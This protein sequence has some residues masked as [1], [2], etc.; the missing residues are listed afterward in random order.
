MI[1]R[2]ELLR[3]KRIAS[4]ANPRVKDWASLADRKARERLGL[5]LAEGAKLVEE[6]LRER[7]SGR[8]RP[9]TLLVS[10]SG[11]ERREAGGLFATA[12]EAG[13]ERVSLS[14]ECFAK[15]SGLKNA[16]GLALALTYSPEE[17]DLATFFDSPDV[18]W[19]IAA[20]VQDPGNAGALAR[21]ALAA[22]CSGCLFLDG[23]DPASPKFLRGSMGAAFR[24]P[25]LA[26][27]A[28]AFAEAWPS[29]GGR[30]IVASTGAA[31]KDFRN[32]DYKPPLALLVGG[33]RGIPAALAGLADD[34]AH[35]PLHGRVESLNLAVAA[36]VILFEAERR[37]RDIRRAEPPS[38]L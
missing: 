8:L 28:E 30:L 5:T 19:L 34:T 3:V 13:V 33:E 16:E 17:P 2:E 22:G 10:D 35:I 31:A 36:G 23:A 9:A 37:W 24:L 11:S 4:K 29:A 12:G 6:G 25:C 14:D 1:P 38:G 27:G 21:T 20:G 15:I 26:G 18:R 32:V 7:E